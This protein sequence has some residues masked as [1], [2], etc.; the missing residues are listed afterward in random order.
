MLIKDKI[1]SLHDG[2]IQYLDK[3]N[4]ELKNEVI[5]LKS[6]LQKIKEQ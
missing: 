4:T 1:F 3:E 6:E 2:I 5:T